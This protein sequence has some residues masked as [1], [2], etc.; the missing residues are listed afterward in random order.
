MSET[1]SLRWE[2]PKRKGKE[3]RIEERIGK[4]RREGEKRKKKLLTP[5]YKDPRGQIRIADIY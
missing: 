1:R 5:S 2:M 4:K 3:R